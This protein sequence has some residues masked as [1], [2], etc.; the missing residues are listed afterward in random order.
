MLTLKF[1]D[2][3]QT[4]WTECF[5]TDLSRLMMVLRPDKTHPK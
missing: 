5:V 1:K 4:I 3:Q 2:S